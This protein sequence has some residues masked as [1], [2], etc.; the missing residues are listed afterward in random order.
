M[1]FIAWEKI[2][3][4][5]W[6]NQLCAVF[7][8]HIDKHTLGTYCVQCADEICAWLLWDTSLE[9]IHIL[10]NVSEGQHKKQKTCKKKKRWLT[11]FSVP[12]KFSSEKDSVWLFTPIFRG[13]TRLLESQLTEPLYRWSSD[14]LFTEQFVNQLNFRVLR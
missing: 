6:W 8:L 10:K 5:I 9:I 14:K 4:Y 2:E 11:S 12:R 1:Q 7:F 3:C 13:S